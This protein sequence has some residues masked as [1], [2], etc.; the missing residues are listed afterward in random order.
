MNF[1]VNFFSF[2]VINVLNGL[3]DTVSFASLSSFRHIIVN[4]NEYFKV[5]L[6]LSF[7]DY[8]LACTVVSATN[9]I[10]AVRFNALVELLYFIC[11][12]EQINVFVCTPCP[13]KKEA[14]SFSTISLAILD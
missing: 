11:F 12:F 10:L 1:R 7:R 14:S 5:L 2:E 9:R 13:V 8:R 4:F 6:I 3:P